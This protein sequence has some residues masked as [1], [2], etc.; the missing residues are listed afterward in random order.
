M[1]SSL[2]EVHL[3]FKPPASPILDSNCQKHLYLAMNS[4]KMYYVNLSVLVICFFFNNKSARN[5]TF[6]ANLRIR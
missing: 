3:I 4:N 1:V 5:G 2:A 6:S